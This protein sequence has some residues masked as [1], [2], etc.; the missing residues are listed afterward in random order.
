MIVL[1]NTSPIIIKSFTPEQV[2]RLLSERVRNLIRNGDA[3]NG[4]PVLDPYEF[5][6]RQVSFGAGEKI[7][8]IVNVTNGIFTGLGNFQLKEFHFSKS[9]ISIELNIVIPLLQFYSEYYEMDGNIYEAVPIKG[10]G[11]ADIEVQNLSL[12]GT[13]HLQ[14][15]ADGKSILLDN[16]E[17]PGFSIE[18][19]VSRTQFDNNIDGIIN[20]MVEELLA[21]YLTRFNKYIAAL[22]SHQVAPLLNPTLDNYDNWDLVAALLFV[23]KTTRMK[24][25]LVLLLCALAAAAPKVGKPTN[26]QTPSAVVSAVE[27]RNVLVNA[28][29]RQLIAYIRRVINNGSSIFGIPPLDPLD[30]EHYHLYIPAGLINLDLELHKIWATGIGSFVVHRSHLDLNDLSFDLDISVPK[31]DASAAD[32]DLIGDFFTAIPLYGKGKAN[33]VIENFRFKAKLFLKQSED[34]KSVLIDRIENAS[35]EIP[36][37]KSELTGVIGG[38]DIDGIVNSMIEEVIIDYVNRFQ[39]AISAAG[40]NLA[41]A[42][43]NPILD[44]L[45]TW[46]YIAVLLPRPPRSE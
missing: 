21:D 3:D 11:I 7:S 40:S 20:S 27:D 2:I 26:V 31:L 24:L 34:E 41:I 37:F 22:Y 19:I 42:G 46:A 35:F 18:R 1:L 30:L 28:L 39:G 23:T 6:W 13:V 16:I 10:Q 43:L 33:F 14:Q 36:S 17:D 5:Q 38:G 15:S 8:A 9:D 32:Y 44:Q 4:V 25:V 29:I 45:D 12:W